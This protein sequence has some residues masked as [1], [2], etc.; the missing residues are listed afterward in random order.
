MTRRLTSLGL[1]ARWLV[2]V[3]GTLAWGAIIV[4]ATLQMS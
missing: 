3:G 1:A 4:W 2:V